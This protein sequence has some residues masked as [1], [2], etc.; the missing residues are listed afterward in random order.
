MVG[1]WPGSPRHEAAGRFPEKER[2]KI[3]VHQQDSGGD[4]PQPQQDLH[5]TGFP[6]CRGEEAGFQ[7]AQWKPDLCRTSRHRPPAEV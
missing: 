2:K 4:R 5:G 3:Y 7:V 1:N 6:P